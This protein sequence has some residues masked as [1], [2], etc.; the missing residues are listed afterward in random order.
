MCD[1]PPCSLCKYMRSEWCRG[2]IKHG[3]GST[4]CS[5]DL[6]PTC[7]LYLSVCKYIVVN[8]NQFDMSNK[9]YCRLLVAR[10]I[11]HNNVLLFEF[12]GLVVNQPTISRH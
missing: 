5:G 12:S 8:V 1:G 4:Y 11:V 3:T 7:E 9:K 10:S 6:I 2:L